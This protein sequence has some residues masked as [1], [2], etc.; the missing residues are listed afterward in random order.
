[1]SQSRTE[2]AVDAFITARRTG[3]HMATLPP[4][5]APHDLAE[6]HALQDATV[7]KLGERVS[8]WK[9]A[10][11]KDREVM[12]GIIVGSRMLRSPASLPASDVPMLGVEGE[13]AFLF[14]RDLPP[15][16]SDYSI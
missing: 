16:N 8:G 1:M 5:S 3:R 6:A 13:I 9:V 12:R 2:A 14:D 15:R 10:L 11:G 4:G 7:A